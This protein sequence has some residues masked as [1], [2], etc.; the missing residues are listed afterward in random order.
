LEYKVV[1]VSSMGWS[2]TN[3]EQAAED[4]AAKVNALLAEKW[5]LQGGVAVGETQTT[6]EPFLFQA[7]VR[8]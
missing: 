6:K 2:G 1:V 4:L 7:L 5:Q 8:G 3:F